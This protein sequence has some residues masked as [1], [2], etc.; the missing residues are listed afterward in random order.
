MFLILLGSGS[1]RSARM[2][3]FGNDLEKQM[4]SKR[5]IASVQMSTG[6]R[7]W[8]HICTANRSHGLGVFPKTG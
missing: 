3:S 8:D 6:I 2:L 4:S 5:F 7:C 1:S